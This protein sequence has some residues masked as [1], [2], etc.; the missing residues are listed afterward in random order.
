MKKRLERSW[1][2]MKRLINDLLFRMRIIDRYVY[3]GI[4]KEHGYRF[5]GLRYRDYPVDANDF[6]YDDINKTNNNETI[7]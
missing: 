1:K 7:R 6:D 3:T 5:I 4:D 2:E